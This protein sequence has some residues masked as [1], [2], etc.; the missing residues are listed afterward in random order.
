MSNARKNSAR[1]RNS[2]RK[3]KKA[4]SRVPSLRHHKASGQGYVVLNGR[5]IYVGKYGTPDAEAK[6]HQVIAEWLAAGRMLPAGPD[7]LTVAEMLAR[8]WHHA[9]SY[10]RNSDGTYSSELDNVRLSLKPVRKLYAH[11]KAAA[12]GPIALRTVRQEMVRQGLSRGNINKR[13]NRIKMVFKWAASMEL[14]PGDGAEDDGASELGPNGEATCAPVTGY[15][16]NPLASELLN[17]CLAAES[18]LLLHYCSA[19][20]WLPSRAI[21][22]HAQA[23]RYHNKRLP[24][25]DL[26]SYAAEQLSAIPMASALIQHDRML[27]LELDVRMIG[28]TE[29]LVQNGHLSLKRIRLGHTD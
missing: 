5:P 21:K 9:R 23:L 22:E 16:R 25:S 27:G 29:K 18:A 10:Y 15:E 26:P 6:Y 12:F 17:E 8:Y 24:F 3:G 28:C 20:H 11:T 19:H 14:V 4:P 1:R 13:V 7:E 2:T